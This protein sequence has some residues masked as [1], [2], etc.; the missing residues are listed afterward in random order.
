MTAPPGYPRT[1]FWVVPLG[2]I[3]LALTVP[4][5]APDGTGMQW[6]E[7]VLGGVAGSTAWT[8][9]RLTR[10]MDARSARPWQVT[11]YAALLFATAQ[12]LTAA[13]PGPELDGFGFD[14]VLLFAGATGP[15]VTCALLA[16]RVSRTRWT[17]L[18]VDGLVIT[19]A[20]LVVTEVLRT[21]LVNPAGAPDDLRSLVLAYGGYAAVMLGVAGA[22]CTV[23]TAALRRSVS[24]M[25]AAVAWQAL[26]ACAEAMAIVDPSWV[27]TAISDVAVALSL[28]TVVVAAGLAPKRL[29][30]RTARDSAPVVSRLGL[31]LVIGAMLSLP[32]AVALLE[33]QGGPHSSAVE[34]GFAVVFTLMALR[35]VLRIREDGR[36]TEFL[37]RSED[38]FRELIETSSDGIAITDDDFHLLFTSPAARNLLGLVA[39][40]DDDVSLLDLVDPADR[41]GVRATLD[42]PA[43][44]GPPLHFRVPRADGP[45]RELEATSTERPGSGRRMLYLRDVTTR[46]HRERELERMAYTDHLT[47]LPNRAQLFEEMAT[48]SDEDRCLLVLDLDGFKA[49]ND[50]A[51]HEAGDHLL[52]EVARRLHTV[53]RADDLVARLGGDKFAVL[54]T[55]GLPEAEDVAQPVVDA[56][57][58]PHRTSD[59]A[60]AVGASVGVAG[61]GP[62]GG[63]LAF[64]EADSALRAAK[65]AGKG[66]VRLADIEDSPLLVPDDELATVI[67]EGV[68]EL[69]LD[70]AGDADG[71]VALLHAVPVWQHAVHGTVRGLELW[72]AAERQGRSSDLQSWVLRQACRAIAGLDDD[73]IGVVVSLPAG[74]VH[75]DGLATEVAAALADSGLAPSRLTLSFAEEALLT[76]SAALVPELEAARRTGVR[77][78]LDNYGMGHSLFALLARI[79]LDLVRVDLAALAARDDTDRAL[80]VLAAIV[81]TTRTFGLTAIAGGIGTPELREA[82][83]AVGVEL[84]QGRGEPHDLTVAE[85]ATVIAVPAG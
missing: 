85:V 20:L 52:V 45:V 79:P 27:W 5:S 25:M 48:P 41:D 43:G 69:R 18:V 7:I 23:S 76:S 70:A 13:F 39:D 75:A 36:V 71:R 34:I 81:R 66:C 68:F 53:V 55:G 24:A 73:R 72:T 54:V 46:R 62:A 28:Q 44:E 40:A 16:R 19:V 14:D 1:V 63:Q 65:R 17:A 78:C 37:V 26:A 8:V 42:V 2:L 33:L 60:F 4:F 6:D 84:V 21:P 77:L 58:M 11:F 50:V 12:W 22:L 10:A 38:D 64:R 9:F 35:L 32:V 56:L 47:G 59:W 74:H 80:L 29:A 31:V 3:G 51:G 30:E 82:V 15:L 67:D 83:V 61:V 57:G 49:V